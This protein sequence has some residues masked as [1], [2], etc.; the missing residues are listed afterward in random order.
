MKSYHSD[1]SIELPGFVAIRNDRYAKRS[2][3]V[4]LYAREYLNYKV[5]KMSDKISSEFLFVE[6]IFPDSKILVGAYY[7]APGGGGRDRHYGRR[8]V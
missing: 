6:L 2:G 5:L 1:K 4:V 8:T 7:K 3:G